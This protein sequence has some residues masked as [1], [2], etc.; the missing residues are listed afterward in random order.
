M[1]I[2][3]LTNYAVSKRIYLLHLSKLG[4]YLKKIFT[5]DHWSIEYIFILFVFL[6]FFS[7]SLDISLS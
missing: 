7:D 3:V 1:M 4:E 6:C 5:T 2:H